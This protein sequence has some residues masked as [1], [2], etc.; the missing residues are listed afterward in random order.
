MP[1]PPI[2]EKAKNKQAEAPQR[3][4]RRWGDDVGSDGMVEDEEDRPGKRRKEKESSST[5]KR[6][7]DA[8]SPPR[9]SAASSR[10]SST[11]K[12]STASA[13]ASGNKERQR[14]FEDKEDMKAGDERAPIARFGGPYESSKDAFRREPGQ[15]RHRNPKSQSTP[16]SASATSSRQPSPA[17]SSGSAAS[18]SGGKGT[19]TNKDVRSQT[20]QEPARRAQQSNADTGWDLS[21]MIQR[22]E[23]GRRG[24][25]PYVQ[26]CPSCSSNFEITKSEADWFLKMN[27]H[28]PRN[29]RDCRT[30]QK[31]QKGA[32]G[33]GAEAKGAGKT[34]GKR[35]REQFEQGWHQEQWHGT[36]HHDQWQSRT[37]KQD[38]WN[39]EHGKT[40][41]DRRGQT[42]TA[43]DESSDKR[44][45]RE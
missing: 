17:Q 10:K 28:L 3:G 24:I 4:R 21:E 25:F 6:L 40:W 42:W 34:A 22:A 27:M 12:R 8:D 16:A 29:C 43:K 19:R 13:S 35:S 33:K 20:P 32:K 39:Q 9:T 11:D 14:A 38:D 31:E 37:W 41:T 44:S 36:S 2:P 30:K 5:D 26:T 45:R 7:F 15:P 1:P 23:E 18:A